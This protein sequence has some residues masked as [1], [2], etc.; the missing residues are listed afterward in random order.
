[1]CW[2]VR[3]RRALALIRIDHH[4]RY[5]G[6]AGT[7]DNV[8]SAAG[9]RGVSVFI[10]FGDERHVVRE[11]DVEE[12]GHLLFREPLLWHKKTPLERLCAGPSDCGEHLG[13][14]LGMKGADFDR[15][16][17]AEALNSRIVRESSHEKSSRS[18]HQQAVLPALV[19]C[20]KNDAT[21]VVL[22]LDQ[23]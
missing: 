22:D 10:D 21:V 12:V 5:L 15:T 19:L 16:T 4:E 9:D 1:M 18:S 11:I 7:N 8:A 17:I 14:V 6:L 2:S 20:R 3:L 23:A 13:L